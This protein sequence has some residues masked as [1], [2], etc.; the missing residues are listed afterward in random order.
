VHILWTIALGIVGTGVLIYLGR[1]IFLIAYRPAVLWQKT[2]N[3]GSEE[4]GAG[5]LL[6]LMCLA[7]FGLYQIS[8]LLLVWMPDDWGWLDGENEWVALRK[9]ISVLFAV[10]TGPTLVQGISENIKARLVYDGLQMEQV[11]IDEIDC[12]CDVR[13]LLKLRKYF[14]LYSTR[15]FNASNHPTYGF[16]QEIDRMNLYPI[17]QHR[18]FLKGVDLIN[19]R[20]KQLKEMGV[21][22]GES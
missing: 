7:G 22:V 10:F 12:A 15:E 11:L 17:V 3:L 16:I 14:E 2:E 21:S 18:L 1:L 8:F 13:Q 4:L 6:L 5:L 19:R 9:F 20:L